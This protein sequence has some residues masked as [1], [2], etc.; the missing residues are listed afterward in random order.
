MC[1]SVAAQIRHGGARAVRDGPGHG[2]DCLH[3]MAY[4]LK[5]KRGVGTK[6]PLRK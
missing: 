4:E 3:R 1:V 5:I 6:G 2:V